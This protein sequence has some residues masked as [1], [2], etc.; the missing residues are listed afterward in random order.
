MPLVVLVVALVQF[1]LA[2]T[3]VVMPVVG[4]R[5]GAAAQQAAEADVARQGFP[6]AVL[7]E[8]RIDFGAS[9]GSVVVAVAIGV[10]LAVLAVLNL[11]GSDL[12]R[13]LT[14]VLQ[15]ILFVAGLVIM[16]GEV[17]TARYVGAAFQKAGLRDIDV[18]AFVDAASAAYPS[19]TRPVILTRFLLTMV[20]SILVVILLALPAADAYYR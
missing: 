17:F 14:W 13:V 18:R 12:G 1:L 7:A 15:P 2:V 6:V 4:M 3:F 16:P 20:G 11:A 5:H 10:C 19:W 8:R 9:R